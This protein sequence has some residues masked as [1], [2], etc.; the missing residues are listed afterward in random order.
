MGDETLTLRGAPVAAKCSHI[1]G[2]KHPIDLWY[3]ADR[4]WLA[5]QSTVDGPRRL[6]YQLK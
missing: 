2:S 1:T 3:G 6:R 5:L 4:Q